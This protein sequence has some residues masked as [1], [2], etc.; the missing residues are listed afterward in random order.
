MCPIVSPPQSHSTNP[1]RRPDV[2]THVLPYGTALLFETAPKA[3]HPLAVLRSL[4][5]HYYDGTL[6]P[7]EISREIAALLPHMSDAA[8]HICSVL[9]GFTR[10]ELL[11]GS[12]IYP[13]Q[14]AAPPL[15]GT[16]QARK[17]LHG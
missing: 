15:D 3:G 7:D 2:D 17:A 8:Q 11:V 1:Q 6:A 4:I 9:A 10:V 16:G 13:A 14:R 5:W 12:V